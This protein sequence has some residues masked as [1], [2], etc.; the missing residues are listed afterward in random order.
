MADVD[1]VGFDEGN[2]SSLPV[3]VQLSRF[4]ILKERAVRI[5]GYWLAP[6]MGSPVL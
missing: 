6:E 2:S 4:Q 3:R 1:V 5:G